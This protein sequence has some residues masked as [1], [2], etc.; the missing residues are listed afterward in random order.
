VANQA[1]TDQT[2]DVSGAVPP[3]AIAEKFRAMDAGQGIA[4]PDRP[5]DEDLSPGFPD[6]IVRSV[7]V[8]RCQRFSRFCVLMNPILPGLRFHL[9]TWPAK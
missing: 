5:D 3:L 8:L 1:H 7:Q 2:I 9:G 4:L 6:S